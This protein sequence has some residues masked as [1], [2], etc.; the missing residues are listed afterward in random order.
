MIPQPRI[1][2][3]QRQAPGFGDRP[4]GDIVGVDL[5]DDASQGKMALQR[6]EAAA[7]GDAT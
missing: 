6:A 2:R 7:Q 5:I 4:L 3:L 1:P